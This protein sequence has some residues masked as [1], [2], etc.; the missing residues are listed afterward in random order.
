MGIDS[1]EKGRAN[2][3]EAVLF[4]GNVITRACVAKF[5][6]KAK[7]NDIDEVRGATGAHDE[8]CGLDVAVYE[9]V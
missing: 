4:V 6:S 7:V 9:R 8:I 2:A 3:M 5:F 1:S